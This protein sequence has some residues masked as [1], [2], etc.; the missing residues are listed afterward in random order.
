M[1]DTP[2]SDYI[3]NNSIEIKSRIIV[4]C[5]AQSRQIRNAASNIFKVLVVRR[6]VGLELDLRFRTANPDYP[7]G[8]L[9]NAHRLIAAD[10]E[11][12]TDRF[13]RLHERQHG[14]HN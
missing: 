5:P 2:R 4:N 8:Q 6:R 7:F 9:A 11:H 12:I 14:G 3:P 13:W 10:I 1:D